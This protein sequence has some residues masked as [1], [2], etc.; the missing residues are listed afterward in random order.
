MQ[1]I[2]IIPARGGSKGLPG[3]NIRPLA[4]HPLIAW[5]ITAARNCHLI[6]VVMLATDSHEIAEIGIRYGAEVPFLRPESVSADTTTTEATLKYSLDRFEEH[7]KKSFDIAVF[8]TATDFFRKPEWIAQAIEALRCDPLLDSAFVAT[9]THKNF[10]EKQNFGS[11]QRFRDWMKVYS[12]RQ[13]RKPSYRED[14][15]LACASRAALWREGK[16]IGDN[17]KL[18]EVESSLTALDIHTELD[19]FL[20]EQAYWWL[21]KNDPSS[22]PRVP[23]PI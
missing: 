16:R 18:I 2:C 9:A 10:W 11:P 6:D 5:P 4:G 22:L 21:N 14:T 15:G 8:L 13:V 19:F 3:K 7:S 12:N 17:V 1:T 23:S 20:V